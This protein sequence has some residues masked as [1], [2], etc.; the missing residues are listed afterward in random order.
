MAG[1]FEFAMMRTRHDIDQKLLAELYYPVHYTP[2]NPP[3][4]GEVEI[5]GVGSALSQQDTGTG[6]STTLSPYDTTMREASGSA[7]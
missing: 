6:S 1:F 2:M 3:K 5:L 7:R 4:K